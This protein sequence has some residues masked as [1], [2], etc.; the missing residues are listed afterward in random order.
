ML[1][2]PA[3]RA[4]IAGSRVRSSML[5]PEL[6][7]N[8]RLI[9]RIGA[10]PLLRAAADAIQPPIQSLLRSATPAVRDALH[11]TRLGH[12]LHAVLTD[13]PIGAWTV[14]A[15][16]DVASVMGAR[17][18]KAGAD[19]AATIGLAGALGAAIAGF[20]DWSDT[21]DDA[22]SV[23]VAHALLNAAATLAYA[24]ALPL[25]LNRARR[26]WGVTA[27]MAGYAF[28]SAGGF[29]G[30]ELSFGKQLGVKHTAEPLWPPADFVPVMA[31]DDLPDGS[32]KRVMVAGLPVLLRREGLVV[33]AVSAICTHR[34]APLDEAAFSDG[35]LHCPWHG[36]VFQFTD[37]TVAGGPATFPLP[38]REARVAAGNIEVR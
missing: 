29:L 31:L 26:G 38:V 34:G 16:L 4:G 2:D 21:S 15:L 30:G 13:I 1:E 33:Q 23:G 27:S 17:R 25:R 28:V 5:N 36:S 14:T 20:A 6:P 8:R 24:V 3:L 37:G 32:V 9:D 35:C 22:R 11:G 10:W 18:L 19:A 12:P 7:F